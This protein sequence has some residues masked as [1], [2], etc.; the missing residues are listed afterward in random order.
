MILIADSGSSKTAWKL[1]DNLEIVN[2]YETIGFNPYI[3]S[4]RE[5]FEVLSSSELLTVKDKV[6]EVQLYAAGCARIANQEILKEP[7]SQFFTKATID[8]HHDLLAAARAT[9]GKDKGMVAI[10]GTGSNSCLYDGKDIVENITSLGYILGDYGGGVDI[11]KTFLSMLLGGDLSKQIEVEFKKEYNLSV[12]DILDAVYKKPL[13]NRYLAGFN[14]FVYQNIQKEELKSLVRDCFNK[15]F[16]TNI[17]KYD[18]HKETPL[19]YV[20][21]IAFLYQDILKEVSS[22][23]G[24]EVGLVIKDPINKLVSYHINN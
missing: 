5:V 8:V 11:G 23:Y 1:V 4:S 22:Q 9:C 21:S 6:E 17:C 20:G 2:S 24:V 13:P 3:I 14:K 15:F 7:L 12:A 19:H 10:L 18:R 16:E